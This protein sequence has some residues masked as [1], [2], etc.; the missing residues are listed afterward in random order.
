MFIQGLALRPSR[1]TA[2]QTQKSSWGQNFWNPSNP[3]VLPF[4]SWCLTL[5]ILLC[6]ASNPGVLLGL[7]IELAQAW[8][9]REDHAILLRDQCQDEVQAS[10]KQVFRIV[11][12]PSKPDY[13]HLCIPESPNLPFAFQESIP[14]GD[15]QASKVWGEWGLK[16][17]HG[18]SCWWQWWRWL[19]HRHNPTLWSFMPR[20]SLYIIPYHNTDC[21]HVFQLL[22]KVCVCVYV[23]VCV[24]LFVPF[25]FRRC[26]RRTRW[27]GGWKGKASDQPKEF[28]YPRVGSWC[29]SEQPRPEILVP[30]LNC[31]YKHY[32]TP[33][34]TI[35]RSNVVSHIFLG[36][37]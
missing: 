12:L 19:R 4:Q 37:K 33:N 14:I 9:L 36:G 28:G 2:S 20:S 32:W 11:V 23:C 3:S 35:T 25:I 34:L 8:P 15:Q 31:K 5:L 30:R 1:S 27:G 22:L 29:P 21:V 16:H 6:C 26:G 13:W 18:P 24:L 7:T 17:E 10:W